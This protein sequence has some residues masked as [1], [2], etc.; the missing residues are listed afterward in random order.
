MTPM[1]VARFL[2]AAVVAAGMTAC[3]A[4]AMRPAVPVT[5]ATPGANDVLVGAW[6]STTDG[7]AHIEATFPVSPPPE[8]PK[9]EGWLFFLR[10]RCAGDG[11]VSIRVSGKTGFAQ[12]H[13]CKCIGKWAVGRTSFPPGTDTGPSDPGPF[14]LAIDRSGGVTSWDVEA[15]AQRVANV[16]PKPSA[17]PT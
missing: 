14:S 5:E 11:T 10:A 4:G 7:T 9:P 3:T 2:A 6:S 16:Y 15:Y 12:T 1:V 13:E 8:V 17:S